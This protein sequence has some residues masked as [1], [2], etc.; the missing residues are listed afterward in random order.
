MC[1]IN[2]IINATS[3]KYKTTVFC[4]RIIANLPLQKYGCVRHSYKVN[5]LSTISRRK[6]LLLNSSKNIIHGKGVG[7]LPQRDHLHQ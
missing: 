2:R 1:R 4:D 7:T 6:P 5:N 3:K